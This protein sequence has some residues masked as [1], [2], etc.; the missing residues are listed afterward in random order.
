MCEQGLQLNAELVGLHLCKLD[1][2]M[3]VSSKQVIDDFFQQLLEKYPGNSII[4]MKYSHHLAATGDADASRTFYYSAIW[5]RIGENK[6]YG[7]DVL[8]AVN[9]IQPDIERRRF[10]SYVLLELNKLKA[11]RPGGA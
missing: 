10:Q 11:L 4:E 3:A 2:L 7:I 5:D 9:S 1:A 8:G 6:H